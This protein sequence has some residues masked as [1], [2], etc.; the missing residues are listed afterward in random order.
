M[1]D[2]VDMAGTVR[3]MGSFKNAGTATER[4]A[5]RRVAKRRVAERRVA[6]RPRKY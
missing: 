3:V 5:E 4:V 2:A 6:E 1:A